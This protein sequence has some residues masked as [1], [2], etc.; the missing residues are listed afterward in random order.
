[1][2]QLIMDSNAASKGTGWRRSNMV[3]SP[4]CFLVRL[5]KQSTRGRSPNA[6]NGTMS[7]PVSSRYLIQSNVFEGLALRH[8]LGGFISIPRACVEPTG[9]TSVSDA[10]THSSYMGSH[11]SKCS[12]TRPPSTR[13]TVAGPHPHDGYALSRASTLA[14][15]T[16]SSAS[17]LSWS[18]MLSDCGSAASRRS[19]TAE[20]WITSGRG[21]ARKTGGVALAFRGAGAGAAGGAEGAALEGRV[22][23]LYTARSSLVILWSAVQR[24]KRPWPSRHLK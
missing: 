13:T 14:P 12:L 3:G 24:T 21:S 18:V 19:S 11:P 17:S 1:M 5:R 2:A 4:P 23:V 15:G 9:P 20:R 10:T 8:P 22:R 16:K 6:S 7:A